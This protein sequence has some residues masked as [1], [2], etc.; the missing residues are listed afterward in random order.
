MS[1]IIAMTGLT[2]AQHDLSVTSNNIANVGTTGFHSSRADFGDIYAQSPY[3]VART[4]TGQGTQLMSVT[5]N[6]AQGAVEQTSNT[7][8]LAI[9]G[10][11]FFIKKSDI[12][13][14]QAVYSR[15]GG[16]GL[17]EDGFVVDN[18]GNYLM[19]RQVAEDGQVLASSMGDLQPIQIPMMAG[20]PSAT[21]T[22][23]MN[24]NFSSN[25]NGIG[26]QAAIPPIAPFN[27][28]DDTTYAK[29]TPIEILDAEGQPR[30]AYAYF[31]QTEEPTPLNQETAFDMQL[32]VDGDIYAPN[33]ATEV[34]FNEFGMPVAPITPFTFA[35][36][37][38]D[39]TISLEGSVLTN[40]NFKINSYQHDGDSKKGLANLQV[41]DAGLIWATYM[42]D[43]AISLG[44]VAMANFNNPHGLKRL[45]NA[46]YIETQESG[47][48]IM[49]QADENGFGNIRASALEGSNV[50]LT[51]ELVNLITAQRNYQANAKAL[52]TST[53]L[54]QTILNMRT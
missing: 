36:N 50:E 14:G 43:D 26:N 31:I 20:T 2:A 38:E 52:E 23:E 40:A 3:T 1:V 37:N 47:R 18:M 9:E 21:E 25:P 22:M 53:S 16:F 39:L 44:Q 41:D 24:V 54:A 4:Q 13:N 33:A 28:M 5:A 8:D 11:G 6:F 32:V 29:S 30:S 7:L 51:G 27:F 35:R 42:G 49:G 45:G 19:S 46:T 12:E 17:N 34:R 10:Q 48:P 15:A